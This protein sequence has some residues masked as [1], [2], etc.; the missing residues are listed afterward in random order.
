MKRKVFPEVVWSEH[1]E[2]FL[3]ST[4]LF[5]R[6]WLLNSYAKRHTWLADSRLLHMAR[7]GPIAA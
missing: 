3:S 5:E 6:L 2:T 4:F 1:F 7:D